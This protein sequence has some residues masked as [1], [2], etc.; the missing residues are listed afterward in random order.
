MHFT[1]CSVDFE[2]LSGRF[3]LRNFLD[4]ASRTLAIF[5]YD[6]KPTG[7]LHFRNLQPIQ[8]DRSREI[9]SCNVEHTVLQLR[10]GGVQEEKVRP[11][12]DSRATRSSIVQA[13][14]SRATP[15]VSVRAAALAATQGGLSRVIVDSSSQDR[16][17]VQ[18]RP[19]SSLR[20]KVSVPNCELADLIGVGFSHARRRH[21]A[22]D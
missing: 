18:D 10:C 3:F 2:V 22:Q 12:R 5:R 7:A 8:T 15:F 14:Y 19:R 17:G 6:L 16:N 21:A 1:R 20:I 13:A 4:G 9:I 11:K